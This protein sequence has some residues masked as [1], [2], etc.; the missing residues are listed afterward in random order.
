MV[1]G[2]HEF[3]LKAFSAV[4][5]VNLTLLAQTF[6]TRGRHVKSTWNWWHRWRRS[7]TLGGRAHGRWGIIG[8]LNWIK[9]YWNSRSIIFQEKD[10]F[11]QKPLIFFRTNSQSNHPKIPIDW[12]D[13]D[14][15]S[16][17]SFPLSCFSRMPLPCFAGFPLVRCKTCQVSITRPRFGL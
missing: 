3:F 5:N 7:P 8:F 9:W 15:A 4:F 11:F 13:L 14:S 1:V 6:T 10:T 2:C 16:G 12:I 17:K